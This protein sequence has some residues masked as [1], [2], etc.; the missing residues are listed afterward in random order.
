MA[1]WTLGRHADV[2]QALRDPMLLPVGQPPG[3][4]ATQR[5]VRHTFAQ[6]LQAEQ[7]DRWRFDMAAQAL[8]V[9]NALPVCTP[10]DL[11]ATVAQPWS[12]EVAL[13]ITGAP[14]AQATVCADLARRILEAAARSEDGS[15]DSQASQAAVE[16]AS[17]LTT[18][19]SGPRLADVQTFVALSQTLPALLAGAWRQLLTQPS[20]LATLRGHPQALSGAVEEL[21]RLGSPSRV[22]F[23]HAAGDT[24]I[25][26]HPIQQGDRV[27]L[28][29]ADANRDPSRF[30]DPGHLDLARDA[31]GHLGLGAG[32]HHCAGAAL[33]RLALVVATEALLTVDLSVQQPFEVGEDGAPNGPG[34]A[35]QGPTPLWAVRRAATAAAAPDR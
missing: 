25:G 13:L 3:D 14:R 6:A 22:V 18:P 15:I 2:L 24:R 30:Q 26:S 5:T 4:T 17:I 33:V 10:L 21:L 16:L 32:R 27:I 34:F 23:R 35:I 20:A 9:V 1:S 8:A 11:V 7:L 28:R 31:A 29:L 19:R 12:L